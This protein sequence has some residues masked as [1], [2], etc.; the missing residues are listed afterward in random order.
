MPKNNIILKVEIIASEAAG[1]TA[2]LT[3]FAKS[4]VRR[5]LK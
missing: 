4:L 5:D 3:V 2:G 1:S